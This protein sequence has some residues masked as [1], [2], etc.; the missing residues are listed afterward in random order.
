MAVT[1]EG[2]PRLL[3]A[4]IGFSGY[5]FFFAQ[6]LREFSLPRVLVDGR[7]APDG[8]AAPCGPS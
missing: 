6:A 8:E 4:G 5:L 2:L 7:T 3:F 1:R